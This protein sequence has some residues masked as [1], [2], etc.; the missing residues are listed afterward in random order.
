MAQRFFLLGIILISFGCDTNDDGFVAILLP[1]CG[2]ENPLEQLDWLRLEVEKRKNDTS[3]DAR[4][5]YI[6]QVESD[7]ITV[8]LYQDCNPLVNKIVPVYNC[9]GE[10]IGIV[11]DDNF[12][13]DLL[14]SRTVIFYPENTLCEFHRD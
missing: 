2:V 5:C 9:S 14:Q 8:F 11:G 7:G 6:S 13:I 12:E 4:Y 10:N 3:E 1:A